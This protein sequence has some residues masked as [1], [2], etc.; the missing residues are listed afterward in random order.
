MNDVDKEIYKI[1]L[2]L[3]KYVDTA[4]DLMGRA[5]ELFEERKDWTV[6]EVKKCRVM[7]FIPLIVMVQKEMNTCRAFTETLKD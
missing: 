7:L 2:D 1:E 6:E 4:K 3:E 5:K